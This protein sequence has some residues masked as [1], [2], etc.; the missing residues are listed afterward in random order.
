M[1][2]TYRLC[3][4]CGELH[5]LADWPD[6][7]REF[8]PDNRSALAAPMIIRDE[9]APLQGQH[10]GQVFTS[11]RKLRQSY[12]DAGVVEVGN[13]S[14]VLA[15]KPRKKIKPDRAAIKFAVNKAVSQI[16]MTTRTGDGITTR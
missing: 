5:S 11:K 16:N 8:V 13:D 3:R 10:N 2:S 1:R 14:S 6:N 4:F 12:R 15:P 7:H 9:M